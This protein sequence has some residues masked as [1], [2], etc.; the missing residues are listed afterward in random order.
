MPLFR[1]QVRLSS[2]LLLGSFSIIFSVLLYTGLSSILNQ[3]LDSRL[4]AISEAWAEFIEESTGVPLE[5]THANVS[6]RKHETTSETDQELRE[7]VRSLIV[8]S[9]DGTIVW[10]GAAARTRPPL[11]GPALAQILRGQTIYDSIQIPDNPPI[12]RISFP[13]RKNGSVRYILQAET[14]M[15]FLQHTLSQLLALLTILTVLTLGMAWIGSRWLADMALTPVEVLSATAERVSG[16]SLKTRVSLAAPYDEFQR[17]A[18]VF[19]EMLERLHRVFETQRR[20][21][22]DAAHELKTPLTVIKGNLEVTLKR[23]RTTEEYREVLLSNFAQVERLIALIRPL[24]T[25]AQFATDRPPLR[26]APLTL[27][28]VLKDLI[29][30]LTLLA[31]N[32]HINL[33]FDARPVH[34]VQ[35]D[36]GWLRHMVI[37]LLDNALRHTPPHGNITVRLDEADRQVV[38]A[39]KDT[40]SG[41]APE[42][43]PHL[44]ERFYRADDSRD[45]ESGGI[46]L[47]LAIVKEIIEA[48][49]GSVRVDSK[50]GEGTVF[51]LALPILE[52]GSEATWAD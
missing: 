7:V 33:T 45:R 25:V 10:K 47:G 42:H 44:F 43:L 13:V 28:P 37:N 29:G 1:N 16:S 52:V 27:E 20:F 11:P 2:L 35:G 19:N 3:Y 15:H 41:I 48:H 39:V 23:A 17:L 50:V 22:A 51:T 34:M 21:M 36:E 9:T 26:L 32:R 18:R 5:S 38:V 24:L 40:G 6:T 46:G 31:E 49:G 4:L 8:L 14:S 30:E 12:R